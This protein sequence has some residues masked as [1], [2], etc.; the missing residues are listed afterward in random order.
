FWV[1]FSSALIYQ[2][3]RK[4]YKN[5]KIGALIVIL[6]FPIIS[7]VQLPFLSFPSQKK[8]QAVA[9]QPN[10]NTYKPFGGFGTPLR[11]LDYLFKLSDSAR[12][13]QTNLILWPESS[14]FPFISNRT[15]SNF[16]S[17]KAK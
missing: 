15:T 8:V 6:I 9:I 12:T 16:A 11:S 3:I 2:A 4:R 10:F 5:L 13:T 14:I 7:L 1:M 17:N